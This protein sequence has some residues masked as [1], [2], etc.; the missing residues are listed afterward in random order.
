MGSWSDLPSDVLE[1]VAQKL[2]H[3]D[4]ANLGAVCKSWRSL[5]LENLPRLP[6]D[7]PLA[8]CHPRPY[9]A[10]ILLLSCKP[11]SD[12]RRYAC[13]RDEKVYRKIF[14]PEAANKWVCGT[15]WGWLVMSGFRGKT[16]SLLNPLT[17]CQFRLP[18]L[19]GSFCAITKAI[20]SLDPTSH[21]HECIIMAIIMNCL[22]FC[23][24][25]GNKW[26]KV[27]G[28]SREIQDV[29]FYQE[30][31]YAVT[32]D[33]SLVSYCGKDP[34]AE[35]KI[36]I[37]Q[38][39]RRPYSKRY[40]VASAGS[41]LQILRMYSRRYKNLNHCCQDQSCDDE[42]HNITWMDAKI[43]RTFKFEVM[44]LIKSGN[45]PFPSSAGNHIVLCSREETSQTNHCWSELE[46][47]R[48]Q[49]LFLGYNTSLSVPSSLSPNC[50]GNQIYF[51]DDHHDDHVSNFLFTNY[52][53]QAC[54]DAGVFNLGNKT[55]T[56]YHPND[57]TNLVPSVWFT[58]NPW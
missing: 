55:L 56:G 17:R 20:I 27:K 3:R 15:N 18:S 2:S 32:K 57:P 38:L 23:T 13:T 7:L 33:G 9:G 42:Q 28:C 22:W 8:L 10:P 11:D 24:I 34:N 43:N 6:K 51:T 5:Y 48:E 53:S 29:V 40:L 16:V 54:H 12:S 26:T 37:H 45:A 41:L 44:E 4:L 30:K 35:A 1:E 47:L 46:S 25:G 52:Q 31:F 58:P 49:S 19:E 50:M 14:I 36:L 39:Q 21:Q